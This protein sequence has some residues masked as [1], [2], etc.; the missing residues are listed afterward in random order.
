MNKDSDLMDWQQEFIATNLLAIGYNAWAGYLGGERGALICSTNSPAVGV[1]GES[2][3]T[4]FIRRS[5]LAAFL[6]AWLA[7]PDTVILRHHSMNAHI[8]EAVDSYNPTTGLVYLL[9]SFNQVTF[10]YLKNLPVSPPQC[11]K[12]VC[13]SWEEF[14]PAI[15]A[16]QKNVVS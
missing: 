16:L 11:Y 4:Y 1:T 7:A 3:Q 9:E 2:F 5:R 12:Q 13:K 10:F 8:L 15:C 14:Q 6:N